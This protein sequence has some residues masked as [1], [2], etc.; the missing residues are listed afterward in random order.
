MVRME[1]IVH[2]S[3]P[4]SDLE[5]SARFYN[6]L[7]G[8]RII[9]KTPS[10]VFLECGADHVVLAK[11]PVPIKINAEGKTTVHHAFKVAAKDFDPALEFLKQK[12]IDIL[13]VE[14]RQDGV[15]LGRSA[16]FL[17]PDGNALEIHDA[18]KMGVS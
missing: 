17:D 18:R 14:D 9:E 10:M 5:R 13:R 12:G 15:F 11:T 6:E 2:F 1:G 7:L 8:M 16:Y 3:I 4:V